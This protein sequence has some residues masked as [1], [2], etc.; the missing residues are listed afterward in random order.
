MLLV[1]GRRAQGDGLAG[2]EVSQRARGDGGASAAL[3]L[4]VPGEVP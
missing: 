1:A 3:D 4:L 2:T